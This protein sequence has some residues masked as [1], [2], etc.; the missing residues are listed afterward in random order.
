[1]RATIASAALRR[2]VDANGKPVEPR[3]VTVEAFNIEVRG[4][5]R[6]TT[7]LAFCSVGPKLRYCQ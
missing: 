1:V 5:L 7:T 6:K 2:Q 3:D 4:A